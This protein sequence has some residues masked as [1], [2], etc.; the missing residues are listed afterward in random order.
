MLVMMAWMTV[1]G[2]IRIQAVKAIRY[3]TFAFYQPNREKIQRLYGQWPSRLA[4]CSALCGLSYYVTFEFEDDFPYL[5]ELKETI[6]NDRY[7]EQIDEIH[8]QR[9]VFLMA[10][11]FVQ[12]F[13]QQAQSIIWILCTLLRLKRKRFVYLV[14]LVWLL[15]PL[16]STV[17]QWCGNFALWL[18]IG[19]SLLRGF[20]LIPSKHPRLGTVGCFS[21]VVVSTIYW[22]KYGTIEIL[23]TLAVAIGAE[24]SWQR[25]VHDI[26]TQTKKRQ[27]EGKK[28]GIFDRAKGCVTDLFTLDDDAV[29]HSSITKEDKTGP[30]I[31]YTK[32]SLSA[33]VSIVVSWAAIGV[34]LDGYDLMTTF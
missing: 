6:Q 33:W 17:V 32:P 13:L 5:Q 15:K 10:H 20:D 21:A 25:T 7:N 12:R 4:F 27:E 16:S 34:C 14:T 8:S 3:S 18:F 9:E 28:P 22:R 11:V 30:N 2:E 31:E 24:V 26:Q 23:L 29:E 19:Q 1:L